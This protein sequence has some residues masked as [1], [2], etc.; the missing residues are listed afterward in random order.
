[1]EQVIAI[2]LQ[3]LNKESKPQG[4]VKNTAGS[5]VNQNLKLSVNT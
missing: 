5:W 1:M 4:T 2:A 3:I